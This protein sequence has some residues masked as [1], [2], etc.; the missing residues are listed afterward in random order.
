MN[1]SRTDGDLIHDALDAYEPWW[2]ADDHDR[3]TDEV[4]VPAD[5]LAKALLA[6]GWKPPESSR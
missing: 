5:T 3:A 4:N 6:A 1:R 2:H